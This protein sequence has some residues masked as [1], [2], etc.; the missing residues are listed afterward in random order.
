MLI[1]RVWLERSYIY[2]AQC[3]VGNMTNRFEGAH[4]WV[5]STDDYALVMSR[6]RTAPPVLQ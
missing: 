3:V 5:L 4:Q 1:M 2:N 6:Y